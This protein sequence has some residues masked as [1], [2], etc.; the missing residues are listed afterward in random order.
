MKKQGLIIQAVLAG[1]ALLFA[2]F[3]WQRAEEGT[4]P[5]RG[6][7]KVVDATKQSL[8]SARI[9]DG[10]RFSEL[11]RVVEGEAQFW[12]TQGYLPGKAPKPPDPVSALSGDAGVALLETP[13]PPTPP[14]RELRANERAKTLF[15]KLTP[16]EASRAL[17]VL[18]DEKLSE[19]GLKDSKRVLEMTVAGA[20]RSFVLSTPQ[21]GVVGSWI[22]DT[23]SKAVYLLEGSSLADL[24]PNSMVLVDRRLH[25]FNASEFDGFKVTVG[26][27]ASEFLQTTTPA[28][29]PTPQNIKV[30]R[31]ESA[32]KPDELVKNWHDKIWNR[33]IVTEV[34][35]KGEN[36]PK[37]TPKPA[38]RIDYSLKGAPKGFV[39]LAFDKKEG[40]WAR[41]EHTASWVA[42]HQGNE[43]LLTEAERFTKK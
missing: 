25:N 22:L 32:D 14:T 29:S 31:R 38:F 41:S 17:G 37:F 30:A 15:E 7:V 33:M 28:G 40:T 2:Y 10:T 8:V 24:D 34:L 36:P 13:P 9:E 18:S 35:G 26:A 11:R 12:I 42:I 39:E 20:K 21:P 16:F 4:A 1:V 43:E 19:L 5:E 6:L 23:N 3:T 27:N